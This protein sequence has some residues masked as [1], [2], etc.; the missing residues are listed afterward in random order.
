MRALL[1]ERT[2]TPEEI[3]QDEKERLEQLEEE[4]QK[5]MLGAD[6][7]SDEDGN[8]YEVAQRPKS[9][10]GDDLGDSFCLDEEKRTKRNWIEQDS[11]EEN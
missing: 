6:D 7:S 2:K 10:S 8:A 9:I 3:A 5:R 1:S 4:C 11:G